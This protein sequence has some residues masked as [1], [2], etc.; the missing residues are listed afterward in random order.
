LAELTQDLP[1]QF[2]GQVMLFSFKHF[3][4]IPDAGRFAELKLPD[5]FT[6]HQVRVRAEV[7]GEK[8]LERTFKWMGQE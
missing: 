8:P 5:G 4:A 1:D 3:Q 7:K 6:P 2:R